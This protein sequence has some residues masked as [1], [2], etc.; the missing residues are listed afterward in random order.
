MTLSEQLERLGYTL[1]Q[2][3]FKDV[4]QEVFA[5]LFPS[6]TDE[7]L[8]K[9]WWEVRRYC[10]EVQRRTFGELKPARRR[11]AHALIMGTLI[12]LRKRRREN[13]TR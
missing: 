6:W 13:T 10:V 7:E 8:S 3:E 11:L 12:N 9:H 4:V 1:G 5:V 2:G